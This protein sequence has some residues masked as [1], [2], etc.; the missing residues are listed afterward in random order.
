[1]EVQPP[2]NFQ[3]QKLG[4]REREKEVRWVG[5]GRII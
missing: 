4:E 3:G 2:E 5:N 1:M